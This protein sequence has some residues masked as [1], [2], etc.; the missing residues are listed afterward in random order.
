MR[1]ADPAHPG[2]SQPDVATAPAPAAGQ[3]EE[4]IAE[5]ISH[6]I[7][8][9]IAMAELAAEQIRESAEREAASIRAEA[10]GDLAPADRPAA[11]LAPAQRG[12]PDLGASQTALDVLERQR[13]ALAALATETDRIETAT[14]HLRAQARALDAERQR[15]YELIGA[16]RQNR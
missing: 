8:S 16:A 15:L 2:P 1:Q 14:E 3:D 10:D 4:P 6:L 12:A 11:D 13:Q 9:V 5:Q 7:A